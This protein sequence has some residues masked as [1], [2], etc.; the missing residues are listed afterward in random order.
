MGASSAERCDEH[1]GS[2]FLVASQGDIGELKQRSGL[3]EV[4][5]DLAKLKFAGLS[6]MALRSAFFAVAQGGR[7]V[8]TDT[9]ASFEQ[10]V[11]PFK[12]GWPTL[13]ALALT[14]MA[15]GCAVDPDQCRNALSFTRVAPPLEQGWSAG[16][17]FSG[18]DEELPAVFRSLDGLCSQ[19]ELHPGQGEIILC[20]PTRDLGFLASYPLV[21]YLVYDLPVG[22][23][24]FPISKKKN[25][26]LSRM[27][28]PRRLV[29]HAR[30]A[31]EP[32]ALAKVPMEFDILAPNVIHRSARGVE[33]NIGFVVVDPRWPD[34]PPKQFEWSTLDVTATNYMRLFR[35]GQPYVDG[36]AFAVSQ[37]V[38]DACPLHDSLGW[39]D[40]E[41]LEWCIRA[42]AMGFLVDMCPQMTAVNSVS[43][44]YPLEY[45]PRPLAH[46]VRRFNRSRR[47]L[48][49]LVTAKFR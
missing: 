13:R 1:S 8:V 3:G 38:F 29:L 26:L 14:T 42:Q 49:N 18:R 45:L 31:L 5:I 11:G 40:C 30:I 24:G 33:E 34:L 7:I 47:L 9:S 17:I 35:H 36:G 15:R 43:K 46:M 10:S 23:T 22:S 16:L 6:R 21:K 19:P 12:I 4:R 2:P 20:G 39:G 25:F 27:R 48:L 28:Y 41:D 32:G 44:A 37:P